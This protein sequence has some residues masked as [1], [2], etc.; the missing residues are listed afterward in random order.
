MI[1]YIDTTLSQYISHHF[2]SVLLYTY[3]LLLEQQCEGDPSHILGPTTIWVH[4]QIRK[5]CPV[6]G[7][8][9]GH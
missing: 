4:T 8:G 7:A 9:P 2:I 5:L 3:L 1:F 6:S